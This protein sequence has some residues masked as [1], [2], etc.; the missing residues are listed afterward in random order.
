MHHS[1]RA[2]AEARCMG[3]INV[4]VVLAVEDLEPEITGTLD[5][6]N[7]GRLGIIA[8][9]TDLDQR[10]TQTDVSVPAGGNEQ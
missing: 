9:F 5:D 1:R 3:I 8:T 7:V 4:L 6:E 10:H 2:P